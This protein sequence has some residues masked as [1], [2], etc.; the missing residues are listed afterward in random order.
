MA[1]SDCKFVISSYYYWDSHQ[2]GCLSAKTGQIHQ[3]CMVEKSYFNWYGYRQVDDV[4]F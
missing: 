4:P 2:L 1:F 3:R